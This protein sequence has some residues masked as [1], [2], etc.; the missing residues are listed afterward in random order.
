MRSH[1]RPHLHVRLWFC[2]LAVLLL[3]AVAPHLCHAQSLNLAAT[4]DDIVLFEAH[5]ALLSGKYDEVEELTRPLGD[6]PQAQVLR[7]RAATARGRHDDAIKWLSPR[8]GRDGAAALELGLI[9][10]RLGRGNE[11]EPLLERVLEGAGSEDLDVQF[12]AARAAHALGLFERA[13][14]LFRDITAVA[15]GDAEVQTAWGQ[16]LL[17]KHN[18][19]DAARSF[20]AALQG[21]RRYPPA[22]VG[23]AR[24]MVEDDPD[25]ARQLT[26]RALTLNPSLVPALVFMAELALD[27][28]EIQ[29]TREWIARAL[30]VDPTSLEA[31]SLDAALAWVEDRRDDFE[32]ITREV[33]T[34][35][36]RYVEVFR[37]A[38][39]HAAH[40]YRFDEA[41]ELTRR[42]L[43]LDPASSAASAELGMHLLRTGDEREARV[44]LDRA[45]R[46]DPYDAV[47]YN[48]LALLDTLDTFV[49]IE[50]GP[51]VLR[52]H[53]DEA[54]VLR[55][56]A[57]QL[58][59]RALS[60]LSARYDFIPR[61]PIL[62]EVF[63]RH[64]DFAVRTLGLPGM[65]GAL[66]A[67]FGRVV[68]L[69]SPRARPPG[70]F[71]WQSTLWHELAH[72]IT[73]QMSNQRVPRWLTEGISTFE[74]R[75]ARRDWG[76]ELEMGFAEAMSRGDLTPL[77]DLNSAF[78]RP[79]SIALAYY[80]ASL[81]VEFITGRWGDAG[82]Q[83]LLRA[84]GDGLETDAAI[85]RALDTTTAALD[86][87]FMAAVEPRFA[88]IRA[89]LEWPEEA[90][91]VRGAVDDLRVL[92]DA[93]PNSYS[94]LM[95]LADALQREDETEAAIETY[96][97]AAALVPST[98]EDSPL[99][100]IAELAE[101][102]GDLPRSASALERLLAHDDSNVEAARRLV[103]LL[104]ADRDRER[105]LHAHR[106]VAEIDPF[107]SVSHSV[108]GREA[109]AAGDFENAARWLRVAAATGP[110]D[111]VSAHC[112]LAEAYIGLGAAADAKR[113]TLAALEIAPTYARAQ[114]LL[115]AI[116]DRRP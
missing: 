95:L 41:V 77:A 104:D 75:R 82:L 86:G 30:D 70:S 17:E 46:D 29:H 96:E 112:D 115:L 102:S 9:F 79:D 44:V 15:G 74:E 105:W 78:S 19:A 47:T 38:G 100:R 53:P 94:V 116:V 34:L 27:D 40:Q 89:A 24:S 48:L 42:A 87:A 80:H 28:R 60:E 92:S 35:N 114:D 23:L 62:I 71:N 61:G 16:L 22:Y 10:L 39:S 93:Y 21:N 72:V 101:S 51:I 56:H 63:P 37:V 12:R 54:P 49:T 14:D 57:L 97:R 113:Q 67:C 103:T 91:V 11:A 7:A 90:S 52:L 33:L 20:R 110:K 65:I 83:R 108:L 36:P 88:P 6:D 58:A 5:R 85:E 3:G 81:V 26:E 4:D 55:E 98:G 76:P 111:A 99:A 106:R 18:R 107:D 109:L 59:Q 43:A 84:Y 66:G 73:L 2:R 32:R 64:D 13:N 31:R 68:T 1:G 8:A 50:A 25:A 45:F 69:D